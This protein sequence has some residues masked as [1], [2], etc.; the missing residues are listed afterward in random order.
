[1]SSTLNDKHSASR[2]VD[3]DTRAHDPRYVVHTTEW[4]PT[5]WWKVDLKTP[6]E[7]ALVILYFRTDFRYRRNGVQ[8]YTSETNSTDPKEGNLCHT[9]TGYPDGTDIDD[10]LHVVCR[11]TWRYLTVFSETDNDHNGVILDFAEVQVWSTATNVALNKPAWISS[12][13]DGI[14]PATKAVD[15]DTTADQDNYVAHTGRGQ[16][17][18][19]W[20]VDLQTP[21]QSARIILYFRTNYIIRRNGVHLYTSG[22]NSSDPTEGNLCDTVT[23]RPDGTDIDDVL[24]VTCP[25]T[26][27]YLTV[28][29]ETD[30]D[31][32][33][34]ILD[35]A[36][37]Q[38]LTCSVGMYGVNCNR[39]C[40]SRHCVGS[41]ESCDS[42][43]GACSSGQFQTGWTG[44]DC[45]VCVEGKYGQS[46]ARD[47]SSRQ[48]MVFS[49]MCD[50]ITGTCPAGGCQDGWM[51]ADC[52]TVCAGGT[53]GPSC[54]RY[55]NSRHC[56]I[57]PAMCGH[58]NGACPG[59]G[60]VDGWMGVDCTSVC[61][62]EQYGAN[63]AKTCSSRHCKTSSPT[64]DRISGACPTGG[65]DAGWMGTDC[66]TECASGH[67]GAN[68][69]KN[70]TLRHCIGDSSCD[71]RQGLC[72]GGCAAG[73]DGTDCTEACTSLMYGPNCVSYCSARHC[74]TNSSTCDGVSGECL[75]GCEDGWT[76][77]DCSSKVNCSDGRY[78]PGCTEFCNSR[79]CKTLSPVCDVTGS[80]ADGCREG[81]QN[82][83]CRTRCKPG[84]YG[85]DCSR[86]GHCDVT[87]NVGDGRCPGECLEGFTGDRCDVDVRASVAKIG[88]IEGA[89]G[90]AIGMSVM[91]LLAVGLI[92]CLLKHGRLK[93]IP[94]NGAD[95]YEGSTT[96]Y[97]EEIPTPGVGDP[98][99]IELND[100]TREREEKSQYDVFQNQVYEN[101][102]I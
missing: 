5:A 70:C 93:W 31:G 79:N 67:Y 54:A 17:I 48:C 71:R 73:Y 68:C 43:T 19:W 66:T 12:A 74:K 91:L 22:T 64:C 57:K 15:G 80:C 40:N 10:V 83:D 41:T 90:M 85:P 76:E 53:Y 97:T 36:E 56:K 2:G 49:S 63:C 59:G 82:A 99:Y 46:C 34:V 37:V 29:T 27:R 45:A 78:G 101:N 61:A 38:V 102:Q 16:T 42:I 62:P 9:V 28:Y 26:W 51:G 8:L 44:T 72:E 4:L 81:W 98:D 20:K 25:G 77:I 1:M 33:G 65:C 47:C 58:V 92:M 35:F 100:V 88:V 23:G 69:G 96:G 21:V 6:V 52:S 50:R 11:G 24:N 7:S 18:A 89:I 86:C 30:N 95:P 75:G 55:C 13:L 84:T 39:T 32:Q 60:C 14:H 87:C 3:G 94:S